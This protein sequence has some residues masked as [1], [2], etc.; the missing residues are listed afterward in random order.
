M[1]MVM[2]LTL[3][4]DMILHEIFTP[5]EPSS[6]RRVP[7]YTRTVDRKCAR[8]GDDSRFVAVFVCGDS[9]SECVPADSMHLHNIARR[10][11]SKTQTFMQ[12]VQDSIHKNSSFACCVPNTSFSL[13]ACVL[14]VLLFSFLVFY[15]CLYATLV[16]ACVYVCVRVCVCVCCVA[17]GM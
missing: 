9:E 7:P 1:C 12:P 4:F 14:R 16:C 17:L 11:D 13:F 2:A 10:H 3:T 5:T 6:H 8:I 15:R